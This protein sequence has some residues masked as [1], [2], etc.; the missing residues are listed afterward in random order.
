MNKSQIKELLARVP[1]LPEMYWH[2]VDH[3]GPT[4]HYAGRN[5]LERL[6]VHLPEWQASACAAR[7]GHPGG[8]NILIFATFRYW[9]EHA[10]LLG[11]ALSGLG[12]RVALSYL[13][14][15]KYKISNNTF[16]LR[17][18]NAYIRSILACASPPLTI[19]PLMNV[20]P[21]RGSF[22]ATI[23]QQVEELS[24]RDAQYSTREEGISPDSDVYRLRRRRNRFAA[25]QSLALLQQTRPQMVIVPNGSVLEFA[26]VYQIA[27]YLDLPVVTFEFDEPRERIRL[28]LNDEVMREDTS[29][30]WEA[31]E[32]EEL[33][34][35][36]LEQLRALMAARQGG[37]DWGDFR[38]RFQDRPRQ[39][40]QGLRSS[41]GLDSRPVVLLAPNVFGDSATLGRQVFSEGLSNWAERSVA[42]FLEKPEVQLVIRIHP[43]EATF[44]YGTSI[45]DVIRERFPRLPAHVKLVEPK[46]PINTY[47]LIEI[48]DLG[49]VYTTTVGLEMALSGVPVIVAGQTHYRSKGF[50]IDATTWEGYF[51]HIEQVLGAPAEYRLSE[52]ELAAAW[53]YAYRFFF[54]FTRPFPWHLLYFWEDVAKWPLGRVLSAEGMARFGATFGAL[55]GEV[56]GWNAGEI[57]VHAR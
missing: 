13:P 7:E 42:Y 18:Q 46:D 8:R 31:F 11:L 30:F 36:Q 22:P 34:P 45:G 6:A 10:C 40:S 49:L 21:G 33:R 44:S 54:D 9:I 57:G 53:R 27:R 20:R 16:D 56:V 2:L 5:T 39:G 3:G 52:E 35:D 25:Q 14:Y 41:L 24:F 37:D 32:N 43:S 19:I 55:A 38:M 1:G 26:V 28:A 51:K 4:I 17:R 29:Q 12:H 47:D 50:T 48:A 15:Y 23:A